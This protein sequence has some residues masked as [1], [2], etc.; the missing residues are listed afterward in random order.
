MLKAGRSGF[1]GGI[2]YKIVVIHP[3]SFHK[4]RSFNA[5]LGH[6]A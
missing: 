2:S 3:A 5:Y 4:K 1:L 6:S